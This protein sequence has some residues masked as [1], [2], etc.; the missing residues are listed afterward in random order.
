M[1]STLLA[2]L[3]GTVCGSVLAAPVK[4]I[5]RIVAVVNNSVITASELNQHV[6]EAV[7]NLKRQGVMPPD[8]DTLRRQVLEQLI[9]DEVQL[10]YAGNNGVSLTDAELDSSVQRLAEHNKLTLAGLK[11]KLAKDGVPYEQFR[12]DVRRQILLTRLKE[13]EV[14]SR[15]S[16][17]DSEVDQVLKSAQGSRH[18]EFHLANIL[19]AVPERADAKTIEERAHRAKQAQEQLKAGKPFA[20]VAASFSDA[21]NGISGGDMGWRNA[22]SL[23]P[24]FLTVLDTL[25]PGDT[26]DVIRIPQGFLI[27]KL[28]DKR[29][30]GTP[31]M[32]QQF[33]VRHILIKVNEGTSEADA[34]VRIDQVRDRIAN[35]AKFEEQAKLY[36]EDSSNSRGG[37]LGWVSPGDTVP[38]FERAVTSLRV[39]ELSKPVRSPFGW[40]LIQVE[41]TRNQDVS[42]ERERLAIKQQIKNRKVEEAYTD[43]ARQLRDSAYVKEKLS[44]NN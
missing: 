36:S 19:I 29:A 24:D 16:V 21:S 12:E 7:A 26:T 17:T 1:K 28:V 27:V 18:D 2:L 31:Q 25:K 38:E 23:T 5:D 41:E 33:R 3:L 32:V 30:Q 6:D 39:G 9:N 44:D 40:H 34:K 13:R 8:Q 15:V 10:Q 35:G 14:E 20:Q 42:G 43:W 4:D 37:E 22:A 11:A